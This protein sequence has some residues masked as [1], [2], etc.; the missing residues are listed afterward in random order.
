[1]AS[2]AVT[3]PGEPGDSLRLW[4]T[5]PAAGTSFAYGQPIFV[6]V[7][8][9]NTG[10]QPV[11]VPQH[12]LDIKSGLLSIMISEVESGARPAAAPKD[13][14]PFTPI[15]Q[16]CFSVAGAH[17]F[18]LAY[19]ES[20]HT[21]ANLAYGAAGSDF[22]DPG[23][24]EL[25]PVLSFHA[26]TQ[27]GFDR[28]VV[29][30]ALRIRVEPPQS[31]SDKRDGDSLH[32]R[33]IGISLALGG[34]SC[35][36]K[37]AGELA[38]IRER[39][40]W[41][42]G[43][44]PPDP[45]AVT[46][47]RAAGIFEGRMGNHHRAVEL[48]NQATTPEAIRHFDPHTAEHT[49]RLAET[50]MARIAGEPNKADPAVVVVDL[51]TSKDGSPLS[52]G[53]GSGL[54]VSRG[55]PSGSSREENAGKRWGVLAP[56]SQLPPEGMKPD[57]QQAVDGK[58]AVAAM[59]TVASGNGLTQRV[60]ARRIDLV[61]EAG[62]DKPTL[63][64]LELTH[65]LP[66]PSD[67]PGP[68]PVRST[69]DAGSAVESF[70]G[71]AAEYAVVSRTGQEL[72][73]WSEAADQALADAPRPRNPVAPTPARVHRYTSLDDVAGWPCWIVTCRQEGP[74]PP[75]DIDT[76]YH[77]LPPPEYPPDEGQSQEQGPS[78]TGA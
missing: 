35:L 6:E 47:A 42:A 61:A 4:L 49:R 75:P 17:Q 74:P 52:G 51:W 37:A 31:R 10:T 21:N 66:A 13:P 39:R 2:G 41:Q 54:L 29:G 58:Q 73:D 1:L 14:M 50:Y 22:V 33:E 28:L 64:L 23:L 40:V 48:L 44:G 26:D 56:A 38:E 46:L 5:P 25:K 69:A 67:G 16:R 53:R 15:M 3:D 55:A 63:A 20:L 57:D 45:I 19:G 78:K 77:E 32:G 12:I 76:R 60:A 59:V 30:P 34:S 9:L 8:L 72:D 62:Q 68:L 70:F 27:D 11:K 36:Q 24:Y 71:G 7:S 43:G 18:E 65:P